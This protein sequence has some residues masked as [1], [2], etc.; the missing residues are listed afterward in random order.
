MVHI[1]RVTLARS[2]APGLRAPGE[3][4]D[5]GAPDANKARERARNQVVTWGGRKS[6]RVCFPGQAHRT[7]RRNPAR[8]S[9]SASGGEVASVRGASAVSGTVV[10][11]RALPAGSETDEA[12]AG[13][14][15]SP[16]GLATPCNRVRPAHNHVTK[17]EQLGRN[18]KDVQLPMKAPAELCRDCVDCGH[19]SSAG[20]RQNSQG[21][22]APYS[23]SPC[24]SPRSEPQFPL[25]VV[26]AAS[27]RFR[28]SRPET[29]L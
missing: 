29:S 7:Q 12:W 26:A 20:R 16:S 10:G 14:A 15:S 4:L 24:L 22:A 19:W 28:V 8:A 11:H 21:S 5:V 18:R 1:R 25:V 9:R 13:P 17:R 6:Q 3:R 23:A 2:P 27:R